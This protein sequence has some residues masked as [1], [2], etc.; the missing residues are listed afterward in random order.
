MSAEHK[1]PPITRFED[2]EIYTSEELVE[3]ARRR[4]L[5]GATILLSGFVW[6]VAGVLPTTIQAI[7]SPETSEGGLLPYKPP[8]ELQNQKLYNVSPNATLSPTTP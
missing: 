4:T 5:L 1:K 8:E 7:L 3:R 2:G 6:S